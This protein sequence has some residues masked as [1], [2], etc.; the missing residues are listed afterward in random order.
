MP[1]GSKV[2]PNY[3]EWGEQYTKKDLQ[4]ALLNVMKTAVENGYGEPLAWHGQGSSEKGLCWLPKIEIENDSESSKIHGSTSMEGGINITCGKK[5]LDFKLTE[6]N[7]I[8]IN[9]SVYDIEVVKPSLARIDK[10]LLIESGVYMKDIE[11]EIENNGRKTITLLGTKDTLGELNNN[12]KLLIPNQQQ[13]K[14]N[15][16]FAILVERT[17][18]GYH[19]LGL[20]ELLI[21]SGEADSLFSKGNEMV[22]IGAVSQLESQAPKSVENIISPQYEAKI[23]VPPKNNSSW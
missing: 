15:K 6:N 18:D 2:K 20:V 17:S 21:D 7:S 1:Y 11:I 19:R 5:D 22:K 16:P 9:A 3:K 13:W 10:G 12:H 23:Q 8:E 4:E 14:S